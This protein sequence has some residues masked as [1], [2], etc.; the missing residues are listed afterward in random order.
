MTALAKSFHGL[1]SFRLCFSF[2]VLLVLCSLSPVAVIAAEK[3]EPGPPKATESPPPPPPVEIPLADIATRATEVSNLVSSLTAAAVS[4]AQIEN[5]AKSLPDL[6]EKLDAQF[7]ATTS[8]LEAEP[9]LD[10][11]Q[12]LQQQWQRHEVAATASLSTLTQQA[13]KLQDGLNQ[14]ADLQ[15]LW[16]NSRQSAEKSKAPDPILQQINATLTAIAAAQAKLQTERVA[17]LDLQS[18]IAQEL[19]K[20]GTALT[21]IGQYQQKAVAGIFVPDGP[22][23]SD[24]GQA[25]FRRLFEQEVTEVT[26]IFSREYSVFS[27]LSWLNFSAP[28]R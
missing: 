8:T 22:R 23:T 13:T 5:I 19:S 28:I 1:P 4:G 15:K 18:R 14:L 7:A 25:R 11:L 21:Q 27:V 17:V 20:C 26:E 10:T 16:N 9:S 12:S 6:S 2:F 3:E 24:E